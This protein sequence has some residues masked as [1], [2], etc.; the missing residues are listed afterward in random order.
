MFRK[1]TDRFYASPQIEVGD[2]AEARSI[3]DPADDTQD[4]HQLLKSGS[5]PSKLPMSMVGATAALI[6]TGLALTVIAGPA[7]AY[8]DHAAEDIL[9]PGAYVTAV[10]SQEA[11]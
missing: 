2:I 1:V 9:G 8:T 6:A 7:F 10:L 11:P 3:V 4:F 5:L